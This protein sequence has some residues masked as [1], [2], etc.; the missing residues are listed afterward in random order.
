MPLRRFF[1]RYAEVSQGADV[2]EL[3]A[4]YAPTFIVAG[5]KGSRAFANDAAFLGWLKQ[6]YD[7]NQTHGMRSLVVMSIY[8]VVL[9]PRH[10]LA[11]VKWGTQFTKTGDHLIEFEIAYLVESHAGGW[12]ILSY[13]S[14]SDQDEEM[15]KHGLL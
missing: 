9:S 14:R 10:S 7:F 15:K 13:I 6:V 11:T 8:E 1:D 5:P 12:T 4:M 2:D 3:A